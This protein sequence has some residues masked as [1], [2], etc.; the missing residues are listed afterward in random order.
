MKTCNFIAILVLLCNF[1]LLKPM[2]VLSQ[3]LTDSTANFFSISSFYDQ[4]Y[5]SL[6]QLRG[7]DSMK[8]TGYKDYLRWK[9][10]YTPRHGVNGDL[11]GI[12][13]GIND[14]YENFDA[15]ENYNDISDWQFTGPYGIPKGHDNAPSGSTGKGM[16]LSLWVSGGD[17]SLIYAG[18]H[19]G[20]L[21]KTTDGGENWFPLHDNDARIFGVNSIAVDPLVMILFT[22]L[23]ILL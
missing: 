3:P 5:D 2:A 19:H 14:Y 17:H 22:L 8:G 21:W 23:E 12:W 13:E 15:P 20:G 6:M 10:F 9:W 11:G 4:Y 1:A 18:S 7:A 16:M